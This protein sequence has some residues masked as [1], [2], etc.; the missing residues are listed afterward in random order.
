MSELSQ[1]TREVVTEGARALGP[2]AAARERIRAGVAARISTGGPAGAGE[3]A[4]GA[5][6]STLKAWLVVLMAGGLVAGAIGWYLGRGA[7]DRAP[8][9]SSPPPRAASPAA[10]APAAR[11]EPSDTTGPDAGPRSTASPPRAPER[12]ARSRPSRAVSEL[13]REIELLDRARRELQSGAPARALVALDR[14]RRELRAPQMARE[15]TLLRAEALCAA[16][17]PREG[18]RALAELD[19]RWPDAPGSAAARAVCG[20]SE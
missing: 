17:R 10:S 20:G 13:E 5:A 16:G 1:A 15:A 7:G 11:S 8:G 6:A 4:A 3:G 14:H 18:E 9:L 12:S 2:S 19:R